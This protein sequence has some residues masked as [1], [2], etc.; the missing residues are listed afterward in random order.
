MV[1]I[2]HKTGKAVLIISSKEI[3]GEMRQ[4]QTYRGVKNYKEIA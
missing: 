1:R 4:R 3:G 2:I